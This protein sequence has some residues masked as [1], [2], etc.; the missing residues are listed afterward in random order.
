MDKLYSDVNFKVYSQSPDIKI[1]NEEAVR[2]S[3]I[4]IVSTSQK[5]R[6]FRRS[7]GFN[8]SQFLA[9]PIS[10]EG[11]I[12]LQLAIQNILDQEEQ[13]AKCEVEV[14][15]DD[16]NQGYLVE[17]VYTLLGFGTTGSINFTISD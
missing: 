7:F 12:A 16:L 6:P 11:A 9:E 1:Y 13:R 10:A 4:T 5:S 3:I 8:F 17:V 14:Y 15:I 2:N